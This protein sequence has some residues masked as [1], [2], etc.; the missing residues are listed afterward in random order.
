M[1]K[2]RFFQKDAYISV[3]FLD[4][5]AEILKIIDAPKKPKKFDMILK[6]AEGDKK[7]IYFEHPSIENGNAILEE[8]NHFADCIEQNKTPIVSLEDGAKALELAN[9]II[10]SFKK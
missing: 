9:L 10:E 2:T 8:F 7:Q 4:K 3:D 6:N 5:K 1:R